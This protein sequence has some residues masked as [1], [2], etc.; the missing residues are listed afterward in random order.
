MRY[1][2]DVSRGALSPSEVPSIVTTPN[3][4][5]KFDYGAAVSRIL[6]VKERSPFPVVGSEIV[7]TV[8]LEDIAN[9]AFP[10]VRRFVFGQIQ[11]GDGVGRVWWRLNNRGQVGHAP[12][13]RVVVDEIQIMQSQATTGTWALEVGRATAVVGLNA[14]FA[15]YCDPFNPDNPSDQL[16]DF[17][18]GGWGLTAA[19]TGANAQFFLVG[20]GLLGV[21]RIP[22]PFIIGQGQA[23]H[24]HQ[25]QVM[26]AGSAGGVMFFG[27]EWPGP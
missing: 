23:V 12:S 19:L 10:S 7:P 14:G 6:Q 4:I 11:T 27:R 18:A 26:A 24:V 25:E 9:S 16:S 13:D 1:R 20:G 5:Q 21:A 15:I 2:V 17:T 22:G 3:L 8:Q